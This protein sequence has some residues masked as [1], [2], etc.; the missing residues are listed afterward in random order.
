MNRLVLVKPSYEYKE[1]IEDM[2]NEWAIYND[3]HDTNHSPWIIFQERQSFDAYLKHFENAELHPNEGQVPATTYFALDKERNIM[4]GA[5]SIR[6]YL[7]EK[8][9][10]G[11]GH[12]GD[13]IRPSERRK[14]YVTEMIGLALQKCREMGIDRVM[15]SCNDDNI[16]S[17]KSIISNGGVFERTAIEDGDLIEIYWI[18]LEK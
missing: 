12:I 13:G 17:R 15:M 8:L 14:G 18:D 2:V 9:R 4:V 7:N 1:Q 6:H 5:I 11:G 16:G 3:T 10:N